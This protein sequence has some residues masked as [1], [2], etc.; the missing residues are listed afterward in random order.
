MTYPQ[1]QRHHIGHEEINFRCVVGRQ[2]I[3]R[4][5][6][7][8]RTWGAALSRGLDLHSGEAVTGIENEVITLI[9]P[10]PGYAEAHAGGLGQKLCL[11]EFPIAPVAA[12]ADCMNIE[13]LSWNVGVVGIVFL[14]FSLHYDSSHDDGCQL[15]A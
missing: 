11:R 12:E 13:S 7:A 10:R 4:K 15:I 2:P 5:H 8:V 9:S 6:H 14:M 1:V 3:A